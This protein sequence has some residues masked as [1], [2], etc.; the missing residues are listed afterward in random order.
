MYVSPTKRMKHQQ[1][2]LHRRTLRPTGMSDVF[3][4]LMETGTGKTKVIL[5]EFQGMFV[6]P[7]CVI[8]DLLVIAP[9]GSYRNWF[10]AKS[11]EQLSEL[12]THLDPKFLKILNVS[13]WQGSGGVQR[14]KDLDAFVK[15]IRRPRAFFINCESL[16]TVDR[17]E[18]LCQ[19]FLKAGRCMMVVDES[20]V[21]RSKKA[22]RAKTIRKLGMMAKARRIMTGLV[23]PKS[24]LDLF[25]Q[26]YFLDWRIIGYESFTAFRSRYAK[27][28]LQ[29]F[30]PNEIIRVKLRQMSGVR[31]GG[32]RLNDNILRDK[33]RKMYGPDVPVSATIPRARLI[34]EIDALNEGMHRNE[35][36]EAIDRLGGYIRQVPL[37]EGYTNLPEL[38]KKIAPFSYQVLKKHCLDLKPKVYV[39]RDVELTKDQ[40][41]IYND[42]LET[43]TAEL[44]KDKFVTAMSVITQMMRL[45]QVVCGHSKDDEEGKIY[46]I[47]S[48][49]I[50][51]IL[52]ILSDHEG[53]AIIWTCYTQ[54]LRKLQ[55]AIEKEFGGGTCA[56]YW[57]GNKSTRD[58]DER[59]FLGDK[60]CRYIVSTQS[61]GGKG[62]TWNVANLTIYAA[63][64]YDLEQRFQSEDRN[65][66]RG[67]KESVTYI[68][69]IARG[70]VEEKIIRCLRKK[71]DLTTIITG[72][73]YREWLI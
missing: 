73:N 52:D 14:Q 22:E 39:P 48:N 34:E 12:E 24:P 25:W 31:N 23:T 29:C 51:T 64:N 44:A 5:D 1:E 46:D 28:N 11:D 2:A 18:K 4:D 32:S 59:R 60:D 26:F 62:N 47:K 30:L 71:L 45:H 38:S 58:D 9:A 36:V 68:D 3:A 33:L 57:G 70:T 16:S 41:R 54:E 67:Q 50:P 43:A 63:S 10:I 55:A 15:D 35:M 27:V 61:A 65:H 72:E 40:H 21:I 42:L 53:K 7:G 66:R 6:T 19:Q 8:R 13:A 56:A 37:I 20:T 49:R 69:V 17:V